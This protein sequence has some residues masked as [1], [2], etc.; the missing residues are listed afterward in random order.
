MSRISEQYT[1]IAEKRPIVY[2]APDHQ[3][4][5]EPC[6][7]CQQSSDQI[8]CCLRGC[9]IIACIIAPILNSPKTPTPTI[10][11]FISPSSSHQP[12]FQHIKSPCELTVDQ[13]P[14]ASCLELHHH[15]VQQG[16]FTTGG[17]K[18]LSGFTRRRS[19]CVCSSSGT[20]TVKERGGVDDGDGW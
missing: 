7:K 13:H 6:S 11:S 10:N 18:L 17:N 9:H 14:V 3:Q 8:L 4:H 5:P 19:R 20:Q 12:V 2:I 16:K 1:Q 15:L